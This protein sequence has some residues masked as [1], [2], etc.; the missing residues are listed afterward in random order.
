M[1]TY[2]KIQPGGKNHTSVSEV[3]AQTIL[4]S[5][6]VEYKQ[7]HNYAAEEAYLY[8]ADTGNEDWHDDYSIAI[9]VKIAGEWHRVPEDSCT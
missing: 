2:F 8:E 1:K 6:K 7:P 3:E 9:A 4:N 5:A